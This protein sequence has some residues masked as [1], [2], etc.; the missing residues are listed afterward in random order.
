MGGG[1]ATDL[2]P[3]NKRFVNISGCFS[4]ELYSKYRFIAI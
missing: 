2:P 4:Y 1:T 3:C